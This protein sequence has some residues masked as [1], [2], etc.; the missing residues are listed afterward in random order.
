MNGSPYKI[1][2]F[3]TYQD[4]TTHEQ[5]KLTL[6]TVNTFSTSLELDGDSPAC[7]NCKQQKKGGILSAAQIP[8]SNKLLRLAAN[9][10]FSE[11]S[12]VKEA[13]IEAY[14]EQNLVWGVVNVSC[15]TLK[16]R[17]GGGTNGIEEKSL[18]GV[19]VISSPRA[20]LSRTAT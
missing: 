7:E 6:G 8:I 13:D 1:F 12:S 10:N 4:S 16:G 14:L 15:P 19:C 3:L 11:L 20:R 18:T 17:L 5:K 2:V 9:P